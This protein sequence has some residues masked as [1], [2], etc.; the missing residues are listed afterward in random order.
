MVV[1]TIVTQNNG[2]TIFFDEPV[3]QVHFIKLISCSLY[4]SWDT[5]K[6]ENIAMLGDKKS[7]LQVNV[8]KINPEHYTLENLAKVIKDLFSKY[9]KYQIETQINTSEAMLQI[10]TLEEKKSPSILIRPNYLASMIR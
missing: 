3:P 7:T 8:P 4:N 9:N 6:T 10:K 1:L 5:L 2:E